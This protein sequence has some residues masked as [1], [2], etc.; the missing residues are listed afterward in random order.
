MQYKIIISK[1]AKLLAKLRGVINVWQDQSHGSY[2]FEHT[3]PVIEKPDRLNQLFYNLARGHAVVEGRRN[4]NENDLKFVA[5]LALD[6]CPR[7]RS[8]LFKALLD[9]S[10]SLNTGKVMSIMECSRPTAL[11]EMKALETLGI[12]DMFQVENEIGQKVDSVILLTDQIKWFV[13]D[14]FQRIRQS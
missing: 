11:K 3:T 6:S 14:E 8:T 7:N 1:C 4:I 2:E 9:N 12:C 10:G 5:E 13:G